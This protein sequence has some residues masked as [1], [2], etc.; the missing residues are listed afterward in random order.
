[1]SK[2]ESFE[3]EIPQLKRDRTVWVYLPDSYKSTGAPL[4]VIYMQDGQNLFYD[5]LT[6][7]GTAWRVD[8][9]MDEI[10]EK[11]GRGA[12]IIGVESYDRA[13]DRKSVV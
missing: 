6:S 12:I 4:P 5:K 2:I 11:T 8:K 13:R 7:Y 3:I 1:M 9:I 10:Y